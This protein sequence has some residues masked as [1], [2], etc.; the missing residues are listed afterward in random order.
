MPRNKTGGKGHRSAKN[1]APKIVVYS[2]GPEQLYGQITGAKG[3]GHFTVKCT[4]GIERL[5][6]MRGAL[7]KRKWVAKDSFVLISIRSDDTEDN[8]GDIIEVY[9]VEQVSQLFRTGKMGKLS[10][11][12]LDQNHGIVFRD[13]E[14]SEMDESEIPTSLKTS[15]LKTPPFMV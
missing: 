13:Q 3:S 11:Q 9:E 7:Y 10:S 8:K 12:G 6:R 15:P 1:Q 2:D 5:C 4:D 14:E